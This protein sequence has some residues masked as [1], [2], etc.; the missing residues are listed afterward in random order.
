MQCCKDHELSRRVRDELHALPYQCWHNAKRAL[1][2]LGRDACYVEGWIVTPE[3]RLVEHGWCEAGGRVVDPSL[4]DAEAEYFPGLRFDTQ[5]I[6]A[7]DRDPYVPIAR[8]LYG[9]TGR[10]C[11]AYCAAFEAARSFAEAEP[12][13][14]RPAPL[15]AKDRPAGV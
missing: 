11:P 14:A 6:A 13:D 4:P 12:G 1:A 15:G 3:G 9:H 5:H 7:L 8:Q 2:C 10:D